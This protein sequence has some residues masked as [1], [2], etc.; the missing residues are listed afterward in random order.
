MTY[1]ALEKEVNSGKISSLYLFYGEERFL[2]DSILKKIK[3]NFGE[4]LQGINYILIDN[5]SV[6]NLIYDIESPAF[7]YDK[8]LII[9]KNS[10]LF[11]KETAKKDGKKEAK[12]KAAVNPMQESITNYILENIDVINESVIL[13]FVEETV[14]KNIV[15]EAINKKGIVCDFQELG[16][17]QLIRRLKQI[18]NAYKVNVDERTLAYFI[19]FAGTNLQ[20]L[21]NEIRKL[22]EFAGENGTITK[23]SIEKLT[24]KQID[25]VIFDLTDNLG[26]RNLTKALNILDELMYQKEPILKI[27]VMLYNHFKKLYLTK[28]A[29]KTNKDMITSLSLKPSQTFLVDKYKNQ[30]RTFSEE[31]LIIILDKFVELDYLSKS[32][33]I[34]VDVGLK[35]LL[36]RYC[37]KDLLT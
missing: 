31:E 4:M 10:G 35:S 20:I 23:E 24:I 17:V 1:D 11:K 13:I 32:G 6:D 8:K 27:L 37:S 21:I 34:D 25:S 28:I 3:K 5:G 33:K 9:V 36:S 16:Q 26:N 14:D 7:G 19:E 22:I 18:A 2:L 12:K 15:Y 29:V 30:A